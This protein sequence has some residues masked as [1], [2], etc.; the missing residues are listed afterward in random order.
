MKYLPY[1]QF[2]INSSPVEGTNYSPLESLSGFPP[3]V[4]LDLYLTPTEDHSFAQDHHQ[5]HVDHPKHMKHIHSVMNKVKKKQREA[6]KERYDQTHRDV[7]YSVGDLVLAYKP[8]G[9]V[10]GPRKLAIDFRGPFKVTEVLGPNTYRVVLARREDLGV[11]TVNVKNMVPFR[12]RSL[13]LATTW[14]QVDSELPRPLPP[15]RFSPDRGRPDVEAAPQGPSEATEKAAGDVHQELEDKYPGRPPEEQALLE[16]RNLWNKN[17]FFAHTN[18]GIGVFARRQLKAHLPLV[19]YTG[20][21]LTASEHETRYAHKTP[22]YTVEREDGSFIDA[23]DFEKSSYARYVNNVGPKEEANLDLVEGDDGRVYYVTR[24]VI[25]EGEELMTDYG[26]EFRWTTKRLSGD[27]QRRSPPARIPLEDLPFAVDPPEPTQP[28]PDHNTQAEE[29]KEA[30]KDTPLLEDNVEINQFV[31]VMLDKAPTPLHLAR[32][33]SVDELREH[34][35][36][37]IYGAYNLSA[38]PA[39]AKFKPAY[40][41]PTDD[42]VVYTFQ[43]KARYTPLT[44]QVFPEHIQS[45]PFQLLRKGQ[46]PLEVTSRPW[47]VEETP[48]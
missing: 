2:A 40:V 35:S 10:K 43:P 31:L 13:R 27:G 30:P 4:P 1:L 46:V 25:E 19:E 17:V 12:E 21:I 24:R 8:D 11:W 14:E 45:E 5:Y 26:T 18:R 44:A 20:E 6:M 36:V 42:K 32:V 38:G 16:L 41:D 37:H 23:V 28:L 47:F 48:E 7:T 33:L 15:P 34:A 29:A 9:S 3:L 22:V 39:K